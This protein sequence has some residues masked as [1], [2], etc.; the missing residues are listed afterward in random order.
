M[1]VLVSSK[2]SENTFTCG[3]IPKNNI[4]FISGAFGQQAQ[5]CK[6]N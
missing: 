4:A 2:L 6:T 3:E 1:N 5:N